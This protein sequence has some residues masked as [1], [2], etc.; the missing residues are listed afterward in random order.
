MIPFKD[1]RFGQASAELEGSYY[2]ELLLKGFLDPWGVVDKVLEGPSCIFLGYKG[3]GKSSIGEH[4]RLLAESEEELFVDHT[5]IS[6]FPYANF[7]KIVSGEAEPESRFPTAWSWIITLSILGSFAKD[8]GAESSLDQVFTSSIQALK[9]VGLLPASGIKEVVIA[10]SKP[11]FKAKLPVLLEMEWDSN[12][13]KA[14]DLDFLHV[15]EHLKNVMLKFRSNSKHVLIIDGLDDILLQKEIQ[16]QSIAAL[17]LEV[18][19]LNSLLYKNNVSAKIVILC[20][21]ELF[22]RL[23]GPNK[24]KFRQDLSV[25]LDW[26]HNPHTPESSNLVH[27]AKTRAALSDPNIKDVFLQLLPKKINNKSILQF[28]I[29]HTRHT[30][31]DFIQLLSHI[32]K[33]ST[34]REVE[35]KNIFSGINSYASKYFMPEIKDELVGYIEQT[36]IDSIFMAL[37]TIKKRTFDISDVS[38]C[39]SSSGN[40][41]GDSLNTILDTLF[42]CSAIG[43]VA[44]NNGSEYFSFKYRNRH[45]FFN[46]DEK[47]ILHTGLKKAMNVIWS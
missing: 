11:K 47:I 18:T 29:M 46:Q 25:E 4:L 5:F 31:R 8:E 6:D 14:N 38:E 2:P 3:A 40:L 16:Y 26:Y 21:T 43:N 33:C 32:Q 30:P 17:V 12:N 41:K 1:I 15:V 7:S 39:L 20:R 28:L 34:R 45:A 23:P 19:R 10:S 27:L 44:T 37:A 13:K 36:K 24:N 9:E 22:E 42:N 35:E